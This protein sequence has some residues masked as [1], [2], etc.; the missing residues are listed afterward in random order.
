MIRVSARDA[1]GSHDILISM[2]TCTSVNG[3]MKSQMGG[4]SLLSAAA[5]SQV[6]GLV[7]ISEGKCESSYRTATCEKV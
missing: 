5:L 2:A 6:T 1:N 3:K 4:V 7:G